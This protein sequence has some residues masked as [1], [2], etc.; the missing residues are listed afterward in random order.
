MD[1]DLRFVL[2]QPTGENLGELNAATAR[3]IDF[4]LDGA[5]T[6]TFGL[7]GDHPTAQLIAELAV[8]LL[9]V[10]DDVA[11]FRGRI[12][13]SSDTLTADAHTCTFSAVDYRG[14]LDRRQLWSDSVLS[15][16]QV[17]QAAV[18][19]TMVADTQSRPG[20]NLGIIAGYGPSTGVL[21]DLDYQPGQP[22][23]TAIAQLGDLAN[24]FEWEI[25]ANRR[26]N[27]FYPQ[28]GN[29]TGIDLVYGQQVTGVQRSLSSTTYANAV[30]YSGQQGLLA[31][32][33]EADPIDPETGRF[34][35]QVGNTAMQ[36]QA[37]VQ[38]AATAE[39]ATAQVLVPGYTVDLVEGWWDPTQLWL[40]DLVNLVVHA[41]RL[42]VNDEQ[43]VVGV[44]ITYDDAGGETVQVSLGQ[45]PPSL[46]SRL[47]GYQSRLE[48]LER[49]LTGS[50]GYLPD[51]PVGAMYSWPGQSPP[52]TWVW[53][54]GSFYDPTLY[55]E[56]FAVLAY[57]WGQSGALFA[58][59]DTRSRVIVGA[60][61]G[62]ELTGRTA[63]TTGG[64][65]TVALSSAANGVHSHVISVNTA[66]ESA[67]HTH[68]SAGGTGIESA[69][70]SH[71]VNL[72]TGGPGALHSHNLGWSA[73]GS[74]AG[75][76]YTYAIMT[77]GNTGTGGD[78]T[79]HAH[80]VV[81]S[82]GTDSTDHTHQFSV[83]TGVESGGHGHTVSGNTNADGSATPHE[84]M[85]PWVAIG[86][87][88]RILPPWRPSL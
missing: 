37:Q 31:V 77:G 52:Q 47:G 74:V 32:E 56:L 38:D 82:T 28:R 33:T 40:G 73:T 55:P 39:L 44:T 8:D 15:Y 20:G 58:V 69:P 53:A 42:Q 54:D 12:G 26:L 46:T 75:G 64:L 3:K 24:G 13:T 71:G 85:P 66:T 72:N 41:G 68:V 61:Q 29:T 35:V 70:H 79:T 1:A 27:I 11:L 18:A 63:G 19:W 25:D 17:D 45:L 65:E 49:S 67:Q 60:G 2:A 5:A 34:E 9:V 14:L 59:P 62:A 83:N 88:I 23:G 48:T 7:P 21:R 50:A 81:G 36:V 78:T 51:A 57:R 16:R 76:A 80:S 43:R 86:Q 6:A 22:I 10:R 30:R 87:I 4:A 84:N